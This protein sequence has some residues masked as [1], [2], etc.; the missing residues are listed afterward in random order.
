ML[1]RTLHLIR[2]A[3]PSAV[4][5][6]TALTSSEH[7]FRSRKSGFNTGLYKGWRLIMPKFHYISFSRVHTAE[8]CWRKSSPL[9][10]S[11]TLKSRLTFLFK[12]SF[13]WLLEIVYY[14]YSWINTWRAEF[15][16]KRLAFSDIITQ[17]DLP[18]FS[19]AGWSKHKQAENNYKSPSR[20]PI[21]KIERNL[22]GIFCLLW[23]Y[24]FS[25]KQNVDQHTVSDFP[26]FENVD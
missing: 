9:N 3:W 5:I 23:L 14:W 19:F 2:L 20:K 16:H 7:H 17:A 24:G 4:R 12:A 25:L 6:N 10:P 11:K 15:V 26:A 22:P 21:A 13:T 18:L 8:V 1:Q